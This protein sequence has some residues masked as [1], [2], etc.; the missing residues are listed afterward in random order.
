MPKQAPH[1]P[2]A[3]TSQWHGT[4]NP[5]HTNDKF[6]YSD[7]FTFLVK[8]DGEVGTASLNIHGAIHQVG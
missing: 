4:F 1:R 7:T 6:S 8:V 2:E 5:L 3:K